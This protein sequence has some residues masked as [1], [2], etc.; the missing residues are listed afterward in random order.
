MPP[1]DKNK[2]ADS[3]SNQ[4]LTQILGKVYAYGASDKVLAL[5]ILLD[6]L[7][8][9]QL[10]RGVAE[11]LLSGELRFARESQGKDRR[12]G[13]TEGVH[14]WKGEQWGGKIGAYR[15]V[16]EKGKGGRVLFCK[17]EVPQCPQI[18]AFCKF[19]S[20]HD[21]QIKVAESIDTD[22][23]QEVV[24]SLVKLAG[25]GMRCYSLIGIQQAPCQETS[26][27][28]VNMEQV[29][30][31]VIKTYSPYIS[32]LMDLLIQKESLLKYLRQ[33][34]TKALQRFDNIMVPTQPALRKSL[35]KPGDTEYQKVVALMK[36]CDALSEKLLRTLPEFVHLMETVGAHLNAIL[37]Q[38]PIVLK[39]S[40]AQPIST[41]QAISKPPEK[42]REK[43][44]ASKLP[45]ADSLSPE[46]IA[47]NELARTLNV[48]L[49]PLRTA[50][51]EDF[52][53]VAAQWEKV[54]KLSIGGNYQRRVL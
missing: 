2:A 13:G 10:P 6:T 46:E 41:G 35:E 27:F 53:K 30:G 39:Q 16:G 25:G 4:L 5:Y 26:S 48:L 47:Q 3:S 20:E 40:V 37:P 1:K 49:G 45:I 24:T 9:D 34:P 19:V 14:I 29:I 54:G 23:I 17:V 50:S 36:S 52:K 33:D 32:N 18:F 51:I 42:V 15:I 7:R 8:L 21:R 28:P 22:D 11:E 43:L 38:K 31:E 44:P 12:E